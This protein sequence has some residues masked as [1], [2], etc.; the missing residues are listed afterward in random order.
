MLMF[1]HVVS[2]EQTIFGSIVS[3]P[4]RVLEGIET[5]KWEKLAITAKHS[6]GPEEEMTPSMSKT[7]SGKEEKDSINPWEKGLGAVNLI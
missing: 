6:V 5:G 3:F 7:L 2:S 4:A 1:R